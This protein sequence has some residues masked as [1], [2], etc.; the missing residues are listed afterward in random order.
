MRA[1]LTA[2]LI[3]LAGCA[4]MQPAP[5]S[6]SPELRFLVYNIHAGKDAAGV[7][8]LGQVA[9][10][11]RDTGADVVLLQ[12]VDSA[13]RRS[14]AV[15]QLEELRRSTGMHAAYGRTLNFQGGGFGIALLSRFPIRTRH[16]LPLSSDAPLPGSDVSKE[17]RGALVAELETPTGTLK[18]IN[19]H[20]D[21]SAQDTQRRREATRLVAVVD[22]LR[23]LGARVVVG[24]DMNSM[25]E[26]AVQDIVRGAGLRDAWQACGSGEGFTFPA[27]AP[28]RRID[29]LYLTGSMRCSTA[30]VIDTQ[31]SDHRPVLV[32]VVVGG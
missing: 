24:G 28:V 2:A 21:A 1:A 26:S 30:G 20:I 11:I 4:T 8:N 5:S 31:A 7:D 29:Y 22:S 12:E 6:S 25:P 17:P 13:T 32:G 9:R 27:S 3:L 18:V 15:D 23:G 19:T 14:G 10:L 16:L